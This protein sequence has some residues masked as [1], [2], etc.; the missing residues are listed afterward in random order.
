[1][2]LTEL[3]TDITALSDYYPADESLNKE[4]HYPISD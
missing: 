4:V 3:V 1:M 2:S